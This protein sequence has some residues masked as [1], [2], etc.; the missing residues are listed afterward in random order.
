MLYRKKN[1]IILRF[2][3][4]IN[5][6]ESE[7]TT[8]FKNKKI[9]IIINNIIQ[10]LNFKGH[11]MFQGFIKSQ[12]F[13]INECNPRIGGASTVTNYLGLNS[14]MSFVSENSNFRKTK[15]KNNK[16]FKTFIIHKTVTPVT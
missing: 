16:R 5:N 7:K 6:G 9:S 3:D 8:I 2:R 14:F 11:I 4:L 15:Q 1:K 13:F 12:K 10:L